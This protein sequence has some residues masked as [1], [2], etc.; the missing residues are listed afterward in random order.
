MYFSA[1]PWVQFQVRD[2]SQHIPHDDLK[3]KF[4]IQK[5]KTTKGKSLQISMDQHEIRGHQLK[6]ISRKHLKNTLN[7][8]P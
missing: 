2:Y 6:V 3:E 4:Y 7:R 5:I 8:Q 1:K